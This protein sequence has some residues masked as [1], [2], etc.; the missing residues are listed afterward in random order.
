MK[1]KFSKASAIVMAILFLGI[2]VLS[3]ELVQLSKTVET[4]R[5]AEMTAD[6]SYETIKNIGEIQADMINRLNT[7][8]EHL[9]NEDLQQ[10]INITR[11]EYSRL[12]DLIYKVL[13]LDKISGEIVEAEIDNEI[14]ITVKKTNK[15]GKEAGEAIKITLS[16]D[17]TA[18]MATEL[19]LVPVS[20]DEF[21]AVLESDLA[22]GF[23]Q[24][25]TFIMANGKAVHIY[26]GD[27]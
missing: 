1:L 25:F 27:N 8:E 24:T 3:I 11:I 20:R 6:S 9:P 15:D 17:F 23:Q 22:G 12:Q 19:T 13:Q 14:I 16:D 21:L 4:L 7:I 26:Q 5:G 2:L 10:F 18:F